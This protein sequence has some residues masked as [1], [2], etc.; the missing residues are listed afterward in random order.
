MLEASAL[1]ADPAPGKAIAPR[2]Y[3][4]LL[5]FPF[6]AMSAHTKQEV[7]PAVPNLEN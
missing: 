6:T 7:V 3:Y 2:M 4:P 5:S 1:R